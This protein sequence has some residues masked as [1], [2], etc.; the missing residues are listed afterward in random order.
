MI[1]ELKSPDV[2]NNKFVLIF[3]KWS[4]IRWITS[5]S[6]DSL[7]ALTGISLTI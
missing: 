3:Q 1:N 4:H 2:I 7:Y 5:F 6:H